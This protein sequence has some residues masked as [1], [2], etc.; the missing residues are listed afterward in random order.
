MDKPI[1]LIFLLVIGK[2]QNR[3]SG[4][5]Y[6]V[7]TKDGDSCQFEGK[8]YKHGERMPCDVCGNMGKCHHGQPAFCTKMWCEKGVCSEPKGVV[9]PCKAAKPRWTY[10][11]LKGRCE[12]FFYGGCE[13]NGNNFESKAACHKKCAPPIEIE[14]CVNK[15][16]GWAGCQVCLAKI[17]TCGGK[18]S[19]GVCQG[20]KLPSDEK[21]PDSPSIKHADYQGLPANPACKGK[22]LGSS[23]RKR[24]CQFN[25]SGK[26][27]TRPAICVEHIGRIRCLRADW[28]G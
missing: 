27:C 5:H 22:Q 4:K 3:S 6:L 8:T 26:C 21:E 11:Q 12:L 24:C 17:W 7:E 15:P 13:G 18:C 1:A 9:G 2:I 25:P 10:D 20:N 19:N 28:Y 23:C 14:S 16:D